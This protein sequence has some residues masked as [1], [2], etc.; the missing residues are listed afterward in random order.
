MMCL[1]IGIRMEAWRS[2]F[3]MSDVERPVNV[4]VGKTTVPATM[5]PNSFS[6]LSVRAMFNA[7]CC[8]ACRVG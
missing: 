7:W 8:S 2:Y 3:G 1:P 4:T 6:T 5:P